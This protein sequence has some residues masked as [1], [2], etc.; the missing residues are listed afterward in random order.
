M[1]FC[2]FL[3]VDLLVRSGYKSISK[4]EFLHIVYNRMYGMARYTV[5]QHPS[6]SVTDGGEWGGENY[7]RAICT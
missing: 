4:P 3:L 5:H 2:W 7:G 1:S 6:E